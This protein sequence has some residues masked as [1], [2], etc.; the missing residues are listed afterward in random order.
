M[1]KEMVLAASVLAASS[2]FAGPQASVQVRGLPGSLTWTNEPV[3][4]SQDGVGSLEIVAGP[5]TDWFVSPYD[6]DVAKSAPLLKFDPGAMFVFSAKVQV[7]FATRWDAGALML[8]SDEHHWAKFALEQSPG[9]KPTVVTVVT[10]GLSD[11]CNSVSLSADTVFLQVTRTESTYAFYYSVD[12]TTWQVVRIFNLK[13]PGTMYLGFEAQS[14]VGSGSSAR[15]SEIH[16]AAM[17]PPNAYT[18]K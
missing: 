13:A 12:G 1:K 4:F 5:K 6:G 14:P 8:W 17:R 3:Q 2:A 7:K 10:Q 11:D 15:F 16:Y 18:G 9:G